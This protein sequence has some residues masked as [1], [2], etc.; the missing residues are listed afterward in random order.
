MIDWEIDGQWEQATAPLTNGTTDRTREHYDLVLDQFNL[1][2]PRYQPVKDPATGNLH[3]FCNVFVADVTRALA[4]P[5]PAVR[6]FAA[7]PDNEVRWREMR[8]NHQARWL[9][10]QRA[11]ING[12]LEV[13][14]E[15]AKL[16]A[17]K[18]C[19]TVVVYDSEDE[20][21]GHIAMVRPATGNDA[22]SVAIAQAGV[23]CFSFGRLERGFGNKPVHFFAHE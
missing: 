1:E 15:G 6:L 23:T 5:I 2:D 16:R 3:T 13:D 9:R 19:P 8:A 10:S 18:G 17:E 14:C 11:Q 7:P 21:P 12:W 4:C 22:R 20:S